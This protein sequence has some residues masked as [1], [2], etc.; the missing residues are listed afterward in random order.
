MCWADIVKYVMS[1]AAWSDIDTLMTGGADWALQFYDS[2]VDENVTLLDRLVEKYSIDINAKFKQ[3]RDKKNLS[4]SP[5]HLVCTKGYSGKAGQHH[6]CSPSD[7]A[8]MI[9]CIVIIV[10]R[11]FV[12]TLGY[13]DYYDGV[14]F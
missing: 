3:A 12:V 8:V 5:I 13:H 7:V 9:T 1:V 6:I 4:L 11:K 2:V 14:V 10:S